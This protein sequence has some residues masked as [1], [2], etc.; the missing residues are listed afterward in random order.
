METVKST[1]ERLISVDRFRG[2][3]IL[4]MVLANFFEGI[5]WIP[6][7]MKHAKPVGITIV[8]LIAPAFFFVIALMFPLSFKKR[9]KRDGSKGAYAH[10]LV[11]GFA[12]M[13]IGLFLSAGESLFVS[14]DGILN[15][16]VLEIIGYSIIIALPFVT[17]PFWIK[18][19]VAIL[20]GLLHQF[21]ILPEFSEAIMSDKYD[22]AR[23][24]GPSSL[25]L[26]S[27]GMSDLFFKEKN[28]FLYVFVSLTL[29]VSGVIINIWIPFQI[30]LYNLSL[31]II[32][33]G[34]TSAAFYIVH[35]ISERF[36]K[37]SDIICKWGR[38][39]LVIFMLHYFLLLIFLVP[40]AAWWYSEVSLPL[41][42]VQT[43][44][45]LLVIHTV[46]L[47]LEKKKILI[48]V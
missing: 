8:D 2:M 30:G 40:S 29:I 27:L 45:Y 48:K 44:C 1:T 17:T 42:I 6:T 46:V 13:G 14:D 32:S 22:M 23:M 35:I 21:L 5:K 39:P 26:F 3:I 4:L 37:K 38:N 24:L 43:V 36:W 9:L 15:F 10:A 31:V 25:L 19:T 41:L 11:R 33:I 28:H 18:F 7:W 47:F 20:F 34:I 16:G 12:I